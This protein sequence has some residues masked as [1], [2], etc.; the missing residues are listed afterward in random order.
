LRFG[1]ERNCPQRQA[2]LDVAGIA[3]YLCYGLRD[4]SHDASE[5]LC[6]ITRNST[7]LV[8]TFQ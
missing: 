2:W 1:K 8:T 7:P 6:H 3:L 5:G 4:M